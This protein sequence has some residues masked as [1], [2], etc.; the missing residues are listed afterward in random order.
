MVDSL[1]QLNF[2]IDLLPS[3]EPSQIPAITQQLKET[4]AILQARSQYYT[5]ITSDSQEQNTGLQDFVISSLLEACIW[6][7]DLATQKIVF[8]EES[9]AL[10][11]KAHY[12]LSEFVALFEET[13]Q[14]K[15]NNA[16]NQL[17][18]EAKGFELLLKTKKDY[19]HKWL[20]ISGK[21]LKKG[22]GTIAFV[23]TLRNV[24]LESHYPQV[25]NTHESSHFVHDLLA[26]ISDGFTVISEDWVFTYANE[27][28]A[29]SLRTTVDKLIGKKIWE[30]FPE[31][32]NGI[33][34]KTCEQVMTQRKMQVVTS[35]F[36][37]WNTWF[38]NRIFP[39]TGGISI[40]STD[41][42][43][44]KRLEI[45]LLKSEAD[46][47]TLIENIP[48][49]IFSVDMQLRLVKCNASFQ[50]F[51]QQITQNVPKKNLSFMDYFGT[52]LSK[53]LLDNLH[54]AVAGKAS[55]IETEI[56][57]DGQVYI[58]E[59]SINPSYDI[60]DEQVGISIF[61]VDI[62]SRKQTQ[63][64][65][66]YNE[67]RYR[68]LF[69]HN[70]NGIFSLDLSGQ[71][72]SANQALAVMLEEPLDN[73]LNSSVKSW[74]L[75]QDFAYLKTLFEEVKEGNPRTF[76][77]DIL[78]QKGNKKRINITHI[79]IIIDGQ[80]EGIYG[81][82]KDITHSYKAEKALAQSE[83]SLNDAQKI[84]RIGSWELDLVNDSL[85]WSDELFSVFGIE[86]DGFTANFEAF[87]K[88]IHPDDRDE[89]MA[90]QNATLRGKQKLDTEHRILLKNGE[91]RYI[92]ERGELITDETGK[93]IILRGTSQDITPRKEI[94]LRLLQERNFLRIVL[95]N[96]PA[97][98]YFKDK[99]YKHLL[100][101]KTGLEFYGVTNEQALIHTTGHDYLDESCISL[102]AAQDQIVLSTAKPLINIKEYFVSKTA[103]LKWL[104]SNKVPMLD[105][106][107]KVIGVVGIS[108]DITDSV[109]K[110]LEQSHLWTISRQLNEVANLTDALQEILKTLACYLDCHIAEAWTMNVDNSQLQLNTWWASNENTIHQTAYP[111]VVSVDKG[112]GLA[113]L[114]WA[115]Q[116]IQQWQGSQNYPELFTPQILATVV[117]KRGFALPIV[118]RNEVIAVLTFF[119]EKT[120]IE[121]DS[122]FFESVSRQIGADLSRR[123]AEDELNRFF[124]FSPDF[125]CILNNTGHF[126]KVNN[127]AAYWLGITHDTPTD[128]L[129]TDFVH[130]D[131]L[132][133]TLAHF[134]ELRAGKK[135]VY[136]ENRFIA[137]QKEIKWFAW[138]IALDNDLGMIIAVA[139]D[140]TDKKQ[141]EQNLMLFKHVMDNMLDMVSLLSPDGQQLYHNRAFSTVTGTD[142]ALQAVDKHAPFVDKTLSEKVYQKILAGEH[143]KNDVQIYNSQAEIVDYYLSAGPI[144]NPHN[145]VVAL[146]GIFTDISE[147][148]KHERD[149]QQ[150]NHQITTIL[151]SITDGFVAVNHNFTVTYMNA[152]A[153]RLFGISRDFLL[154]KNLFDKFDKN[155]PLDF[156]PAYAQAIEEN[157]AVAF[158]SYYEPSR[159]WFHINAYPSENSLS[160]FYKDVT[161]QKL[162][163]ELARI[164]K[165]T[166]EFNTIPDNT[167]QQVLQFYI[168]K[169]GSLQN[170]IV[171]TIWQIEDDVLHPL[172]C[173]NLCPKLVEAIQRS[174]YSGVKESYFKQ[175]I[176]ST[177]KRFV[178]N[179]YQSEAWKPYWDLL[180]QQKISSC[181]SIP[182]ISSG[183][184]IIGVLAYF[185]YDERVPTREE[186]NTIESVRK[187]ITLIFENKLSEQAIRES[188]KRYDLVAKATNDVIWD[189]DLNTEKIIWNE[190]IEHI[191]GY[192]DAIRESSYDWWLSNVHEND[193]N[194]VNKSLG[195]HII[196]KKTHWEEEY[197]FRC[198]DN[199]YRFVYD[200]GFTIYDE[201]N[202]AIRM[203]G[204][205]Q[206]ISIIKQTERK[207][208][209]LNTEL[210]NRAQELATSNEELERF[211]YVAS[212]DLQEPLRMVSSFL[213]LLKKKYDS[214]LDEQAQK[215]IYFAVNGSERMKQLIMDLLEYSRVG[216]NKDAFVL[217]DLNEVLTE[218]LQIYDEKIKKEEACVS[219]AILPTIWGNRVQLTQLFQNLIGNALKYRGQQKPV[220]TID[221][222]QNEEEWV[223]SVQDNG[224][225]IDPMY[226]KK[227]FIIF[228]RLHSKNEYSGT[229]IG[230]AICK[231]IIER[232]KG[233]IWL[234]SKPEQG[235]TFYFS[236]PQS[237]KNVT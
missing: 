89:F 142:I 58:Y 30:L 94:E 119:S 50:A 139:K 123:K 66:Q 205:M 109:K 118:F 211:A 27:Q 74:I 146:F 72:T 149:L 93:G 163:E 183:N 130:P 133:L 45:S 230:L 16:L 103:G 62:T 151:E 197:L 181:W 187:V 48:Y 165:E 207:L 134:E 56:T 158:D 170:N 221:I 117:I 75:P 166:L 84:A 125:L 176:F 20:E 4:T 157:V 232:H 86:K 223:F 90:Q 110:E 96:I 215:Y 188:N 156:Y 61:M 144:M 107:G 10:L 13:A 108:R 190:G 229:G 81:V 39:S 164:E 100:V 8:T 26:G 41:M 233:H 224:I 92:H 153:E 189:L 65:L 160:I 147:R 101:N 113:G 9:I 235:S 87:A 177:K 162:I 206:D 95:D 35:H 15:L 132:V 24:D 141:N 79:P 143:W 47:T 208:N 204:A 40:F 171:S 104:Q 140:I 148:K 11:N 193:K 186:E 18:N 150:Y 217:V 138:T 116:R 42:T 105:E 59:A 28:V 32:T 49:V 19:A 159:R 54:G 7:Y 14:Y 73:I 161:E 88:T 33:F 174:G 218:V 46:L 135:V 111:V 78:V 154:H 120:D 195:Q 225:G 23:G 37:P 173:S 128:T 202:N 131:D 185:S 3:V 222:A 34:Q 121:S 180:K 44:Q 198:A 67:Q 43:A 38:H 182:I 179:L 129:Y 209:E 64:I 60:H 98:V 226:F 201:N 237:L 231:K 76:E 137:Q 196:D 220:I 227:I 97:Y 169:V 115:T 36:A 172:A 184:K 12:E 6:E 175:P 1:M 17:F 82:L 22:N 145:E 91:V 152:E 203:I 219:V 191:F 155:A 2:L 31:F 167:L 178:K 228:Q 102:L 236:I 29:Q 21:P 200:R 25:I 122:S 214:Q 168:D 70:P 213:Q 53:E 52:K 194:R 124:D 5:K 234:E 99:D 199:T 127:V 77:I 69:D 212:H 192:A 210:E 126:K 80:I 57:I 68:S 216:T 63:R 55:F 83:K 136:F 51:G 112:E 114:S 71:F 85:Q 106:H